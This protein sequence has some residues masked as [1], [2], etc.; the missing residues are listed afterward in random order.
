M[1]VSWN[2]QKNCKKLLGFFGMG[3]IGLEKKEE[4]LAEDKEAEE[5]P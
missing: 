4:E 3:K 5:K 2:A 1:A